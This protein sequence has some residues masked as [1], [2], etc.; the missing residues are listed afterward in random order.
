MKRALR[1]AIACV[2]LLVADPALAQPYWV[3]EDVR[4]PETAAS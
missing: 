4:T 1:L 2:P 3:F